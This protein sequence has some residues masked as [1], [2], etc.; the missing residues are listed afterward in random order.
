MVTYS[1]SELHF[2]REKPQRGSA[3]GP[4][5]LKDRNSENHHPQVARKLNWWQRGWPSHD[6]ACAL[7]ISTARCIL[8]DVK[9]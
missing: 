6:C 7:T 8:S 5:V 2:E 9:L 4:H 1:Y 3:C